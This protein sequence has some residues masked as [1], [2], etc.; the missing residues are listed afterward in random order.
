MSVSSISISSNY[1]RVAF[2]ETGFGFVL[3][4]DSVSISR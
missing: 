2:V 4:S 3:D 1:G